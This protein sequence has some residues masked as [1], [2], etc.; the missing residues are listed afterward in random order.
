MAK[1]APQDLRNLKQVIE[2]GHSIIAAGALV[3]L[4]LNLVRPDRKFDLAVLVLNAENGW[5]SA[6]GV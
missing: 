2:F 4:K 5:R 1:S 6:G 3:V